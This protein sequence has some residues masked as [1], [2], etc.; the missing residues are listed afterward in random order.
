MKQIHKVFQAL[1]SDIGDHFGFVEKAE[2]RP[3]KLQG[4]FP[5]ANMHTG[6]I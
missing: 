6:N 5:K 3:K 1:E 2:K 4:K